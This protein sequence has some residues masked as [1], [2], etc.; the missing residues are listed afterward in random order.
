VVWTDV[1]PFDDTIHA[2]LV[3]ERLLSTVS[4]FLGALAA[5]VAAIGLYG[6]M[7]HQVAQRRSEIGVRIALGARRRDILL[8]VLGQAGA[9]V[10]VGVALGGVLALAASAPVRSLL[11][12]LEANMAPML[13]IAAGVLA[14]TGALAS[15]V[16]AGR[17]ARLEPQ[18]ALTLG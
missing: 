13:L 15:Y 11:F 4:G 3:R 8:M 6:V 14:A 7:S 1:R 10:A 16:P 18:A 2:G 12:G 17:A 9:L 5:L